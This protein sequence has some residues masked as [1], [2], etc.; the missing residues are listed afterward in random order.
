MAKLPAPFQAY[1]NLREG[2]TSDKLSN[3]KASIQG[4]LK[5]RDLIYEQKLRALAATAVNALSYPPLSAS[6]AKLLETGVICLLGEGAAPYHPRYV[7]PN[8]DKLLREG[9]KFMELSPA[10]NLFEATAALLTAY[11]YSPSGGYPVFIGRLDELL[12]PYIDTVSEETAYQI[13]RSFWQL[14]D[15]L[16]PSSFVHGNIGP[17]ESRVGN[18]LLDVDKELRTLTNLTLRYDPAVTPDYF[19]E[20]AVAGALTNAKPYFLNH[21]MMVADWG[22][23][24]VVASC[25]NG[26]RLGGGIYTLVR[27][28]LKEAAAFAEA[29]PEDFLDNVLPRIAPLWIEIIDSRSRHIVEDVGWFEDNYWVEEGFLHQEKFSAYAGIFGL[30]ESVNLLM[31]K[32]GHPE[33]R[34]GHDAHANNLAKAITDRIHTLIKAYPLDTCPGTAGYACY[35]AQVGITEDVDISPATRI[36]A[37]EEPDLYAHITAEAL[38]HE[39]LL[40]GVST[41]LEFDQTAAKNPSAVLDV[42]KGAFEKGTRNLSIGSANSE[43]VR[44]TGYLI[45]RADMEAAKNERALRHDS[46]IFG[47]GFMVTK[48]NNLRRVTRKV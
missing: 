13:I 24:Y 4:I 19:A 37:G 25:Y 23:D 5:A 14:V 10:E 36:P 38:N 32:S 31:E 42:I 12:E 39:F 6:A 48:P 33:K 17:A 22:E 28:N 15:R 40:G 30:A 16:N 43:F 46:G 20:K 11:N 47:T 44:V 3:Y 2:L 7:A 27:L 41:I 34:Y 9:S 1:E 35:H 21:Q 8:Y 45:R 29:G 18:I 26:M